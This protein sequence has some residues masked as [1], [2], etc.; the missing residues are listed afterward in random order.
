[1]AGTSRATYMY[2]GEHCGEHDLK[3]LNMIGIFIENYGDFKIMC[4]AAEFVVVVLECC[5]CSTTITRLLSARGY[6]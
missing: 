2:I 5:S 4:G 3:F 1:M 6:L